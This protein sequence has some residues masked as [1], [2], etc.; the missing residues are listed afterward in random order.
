MCCCRQQSRDRIRSETVNARGKVWNFR[1]SVWVD[2]FFWLSSLIKRYSDACLSLFLPISNCELCLCC[3]LCY[4]LSLLFSLSSSKQSLL[5]SACLLLPTFASPC[6]SVCL[7]VCLSVWL[8]VCLYVSTSVSAC[9]SAD[10][11]WHVYVLSYAPLFLVF[12]GRT[13]MWS[14]TFLTWRST[15]RLVL[16]FILWLR[17]VI[18]IQ[19]STARTRSVGAAVAQRIHYLAKCMKLH[20]GQTG[21]TLISYNKKILFS[22]QTDRL[23][24]DYS[25]VWTDDHKLL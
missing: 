8:S 3:C 23:Q 1:V 11:F 15:C 9:F 22:I 5:L 4:Y 12:Y 25:T 13:P 19:P 21:T 20:A 24:N 10:C 7:F 17:V 16:P 18:T 2:G 14:T 6:L